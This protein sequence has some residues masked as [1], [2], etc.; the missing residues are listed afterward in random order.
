MLTFV[1]RFRHFEDPL[2]C[3]WQPNRVPMEACRLEF[4]F[5]ILMTFLTIL[6]FAIIGRALM[7]WFDRGMTNPI[8]QVL[9]QITEPIIAPIRRVVPSAGMLDLSPMVAILLILVLQRM[10]STALAQ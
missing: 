6:Q 4:L 8:S 2:M 9:V 1:V 10:L 7:S 3:V 5:S